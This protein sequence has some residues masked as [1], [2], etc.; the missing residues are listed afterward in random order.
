MNAS[1]NAASTGTR[2]NRA[3][4]RKFGRMK[5]HP[6]RMERQC[7]RRRGARGPPGAGCVITCA[8]VLRDSFANQAGAPRRPPSHSLAEALALHAVVLR[9]DPLGPGFV[10]VHDHLVLFPEDGVG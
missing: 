1:A 6:I 4:P 5:L 7:R 3:K 10:A 2:V 8:M 9:L